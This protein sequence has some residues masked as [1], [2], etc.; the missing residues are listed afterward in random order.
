MTVESRVPSLKQSQR[1]YRR[2][3]IRQAIALAIG[4]L[5]VT[6]A[7]AVNFQFFYDDAPGTGFLDTTLG[8][9]R[10]KALAEA[11]AIWGRLIMSSHAGETIVV[12]ASFEALASTTLASA[13]ANFHYSEFSSSL[14]R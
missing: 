9:E 10:Q 11:A 4:C 12:R 3:R 6:S 2:S 8:A 7:S 5:T 14:K 1:A 13:S